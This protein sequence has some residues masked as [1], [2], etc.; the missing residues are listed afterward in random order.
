MAER[1][2]LMRWIL[3]PTLVQLPVFVSFFGVLRQMAKE[4]HLL[5]GLAAGGTAWIPALHLPDPTGALPLL[6]A[7]LSA[8]AIKAN[9]NMQGMTQLGLTPGGQKLVFGV[10]SVA[11][12]LIAL[13][14][15]GVRVYKREGQ[16]IGS[17]PCMLPSPPSHPPNPPPP[18]RPPQTVQLYITVTSATMLV[19]QLLLRAK[20]VRT[21]LGFP[22]D[23]PLPPSVLVE[24]QRKRD[25][26]LG[27]AGNPMIDSMRGLT[28]LFKRASD[29]AEGRWR[30]EPQHAYVTLMGVRDPGVPPPPPAVASLPAA[31]P[32]AAGAGAG[33]GVAAGPGAATAAGAPAAA[34]KLYTTQRPAKKGGQQ[35]K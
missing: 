34:P 5:Q 20:P 32:A 10:L 22:P 18:H 1:G 31:A 26:M 2:L 21:A 8:A 27:A 4:G 9:N 17:R 7:V 6:S 29:I 16:G 23:W 35:L 13:S 24:R 19:Q 28:P 14:M 12:N 33:A 15:P 11:F 3:L 30:A 25:A